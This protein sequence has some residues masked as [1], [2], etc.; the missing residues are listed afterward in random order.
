MM[1]PVMQR[2]SAALVAV[3]IVANALATAV[4]CAGWKSSPAER[5]ACCLE[6]NHGCPDQMLADA[7]CARSEQ[8]QQPVTTVAGSNDLSTSAV[9]LTPVVLYPAD[10]LRSMVAARSVGPSRHLHP[11]RSPV[12]RSPILRV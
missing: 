11:P 10:Y 7:C 3:F 2:A 12:T 5:M 4:D 9:P 1:E 6:A 8:S